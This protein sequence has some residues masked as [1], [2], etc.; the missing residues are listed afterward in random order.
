MDKGQVP[1]PI[2][3]TLNKDGTDVDCQGPLYTDAEFLL[4]GE[5][6]VEM[7]KM[8]KMIMTALK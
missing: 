3:P 4:V 8:E 6:G 7:A 1:A 2:L 5:K